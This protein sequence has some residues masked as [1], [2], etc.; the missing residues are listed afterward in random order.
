M[1][2]ADIFWGT[3]IR[4]NTFAK[5]I[6]DNCII[7]SWQIESSLEMHSFNVDTEIDK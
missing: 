1:F 3:Y 4:F 2:L 5:N 6:P 7:I